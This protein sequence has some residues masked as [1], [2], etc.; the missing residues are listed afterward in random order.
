M[1]VCIHADSFVIQFAYMVCFRLGALVDA[2]GRKEE[3]CRFAVRSFV[4][5]CHIQNVLLAR[6]NRR[7]AE[8]EVATVKVSYLALHE[9]AIQPVVKPVVVEVFFKIV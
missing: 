4:E 2:V 1:S 7:I 8:V 5:S 3:P 9:H 6:I